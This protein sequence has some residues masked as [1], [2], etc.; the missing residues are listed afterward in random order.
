MRVLAFLFESLLLATIVYL[1]KHPNVY[2]ERLL[3]FGR[4]WGFFFALVT[5]VCII[6]FAFGVASPRVANN[7]TRMNRMTLFKRAAILQDIIIALVSLA[8]GR[9]WF[10]LCYMAIVGGGFIARDQGRRYLT[11]VKVNAKTKHAIIDV[12]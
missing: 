10:F 3:F 5:F 8:F 7:A 9:W 11:K 6:G 12:N 1:E 2:I 4:A